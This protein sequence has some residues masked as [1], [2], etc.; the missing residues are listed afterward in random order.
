MLNAT[1]DNNPFT[2]QERYDWSRRFVTVNY[3]T[4][5]DRNSKRKI[6][7]VRHDDGREF[8]IPFEQFMFK[9]TILG[10]KF[11]IQRVW[12]FNNL[13]NDNV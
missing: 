5:V 10:L 12:I 1:I 6:A 7:K 8:V 11:L 13:G 2:P 4:V 3:L 9:E